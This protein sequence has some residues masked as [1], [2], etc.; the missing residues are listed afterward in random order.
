MVESQ[1]LVGSVDDDADRV[2]ADRVGSWTSA[3]ALV[4]PRARKSSHTRA[5]TELEPRQ[6]L[7]LGTEAA[8]TVACAPRL[9]LREHERSSIARDQID[10][11]VAGPDVTRD[12]HESETTE[13]ANCQILAERAERTTPVTACGGT[14]GDRF[15]GAH[16]PTI[17]Q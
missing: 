17:R 7:V 11:S 6:R 8:A 16:D 15:F 4:Q 10:L 5:L 13:M 14:D 1:Q 9:D 2:E 3:G 12:N